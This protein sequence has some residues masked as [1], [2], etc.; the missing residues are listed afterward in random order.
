MCAPAD[1]AVIPEASLQLAALA[2]ILIAAKCEEREE[3]IPRF[4]RLLQC[5]TRRYTAAELEAM[6]MIV[7]QASDWNMVTVV[8]ACYTEYYCRHSITAED[9][10][11]DLPVIDPVRWVA[12]PLPRHLS[13]CD[14]A[15]A[16]QYY[17]QR[18][19]RPAGLNRCPCFSHLPECRSVSRIPCETM[20]S[21]SWSR[22]VGSL[23]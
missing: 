7:L 11:C 17:A 20:Q 18:S 22:P 14:A 4:R 1:Q 23:R 8:P 3:D 6:E 13:Y 16:L 15:S 21:F 2:C 9:T 10:V 12:A 19:Q 5:P